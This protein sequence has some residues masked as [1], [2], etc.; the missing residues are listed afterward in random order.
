VWVRGAGPR[1]SAIEER[2]GDEFSYINDNGNL[3]ID[4]RATRAFRKLNDET[5]ACRPVS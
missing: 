1:F 2:F 4:K 3:A 5:V